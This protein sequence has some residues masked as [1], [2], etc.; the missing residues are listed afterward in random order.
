MLCNRYSKYAKMRPA[1]AM[2]PIESSRWERGID[3]TSPARNAQDAARFV[4][5]GGFVLGQTVLQHKR[6]V[7]WLTRAASRFLSRR[8][9][10]SHGYACRL[11]HRTRNAR[12]CRRNRAAFRRLPPVLQTSNRSAEST[13]VSLGAIA[14]GRITRFRRARVVTRSRADRLHAALSVVLLDANAASLGPQRLVRDAGLAPAR[15][16]ACTPVESTRFC[17]RQQRC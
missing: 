11:F 13:S 4:C 12:R 1:I 2:S 3:L 16:R 14:P 15:R 6:A 7:G 9:I 17:A 10:L 5:A 8:Q